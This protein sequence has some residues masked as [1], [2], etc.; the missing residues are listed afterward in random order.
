MREMKYFI[1]NN[2]WFQGK[3]QPPRKVLLEFV[4]PNKDGL[5]ATCYDTD[6][7]QYQLLLTD[8]RDDHPIEKG[9]VKK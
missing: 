5:T 1:D 4:I 3:R 7:D 8:I 2:I 6:G 9:G